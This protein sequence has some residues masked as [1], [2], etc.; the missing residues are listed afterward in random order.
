ME[1]VAADQ[2][3]ESILFG[4]GTAWGEPVARDVLRT[5]KPW[6]APMAELV[7]AEQRQKLEALDMH[8]LISVPV[9]STSEILPSPDGGT[10]AAGNGGAERSPEVYG[11][12]NLYRKDTSVLPAE[13]LNALLAFGYQ[14]ARALKNVKRWERLN[15][16]MQTAQ[17]L[18]ARLLGRERFISQLQLKIGQLEKELSRWRQ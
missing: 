15:T 1:V 3:P 16:E 2:I 11:I 5:G 12:L 17:S 14:A 13:Q 6:L 7:P 9:R 4:P 18:N 8:Y 10:I